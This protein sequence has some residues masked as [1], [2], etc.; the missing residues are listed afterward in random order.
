MNVPVIRKSS[1]PTIQDNP[2]FEKC[3]WL[4]T[5]VSPNRIYAYNE[6]TK[7]WEPISDIGNKNLNTKDPIE[8]YRVWIGTKD[9][10]ENLD[11]LEDDVIYSVKGVGD[12]IGNKPMFSMIP[13]VKFVNKDYQ[14]KRNLGCSWD[15]PFKNIQEAIDNALD[16][17]RIWV[18]SGTYVYNNPTNSTSS[19]LVNKKLE[20]IGGFT[21]NELSYSEKSLSNKT[22]LDGEKTRR[23]FS[24]GNKSNGSVVEGFSLVNG[25]AGNENGGAI[26]STGSI[27]I[28][29]CEFKNNS[30]SLGGAVYNVTTILGCIF[31]KNTATSNG[32]SIFLT[33]QGIINSCTITRGVGNNAISADSNVT[34][35]L[36]NT[37]IWNNISGGDSVQCGSNSMVLNCAS[38]SNLSK[39]SNTNI[40]LDYDGSIIFTDPDNGDFSIIKDSP[41]INKGLLNVY[42]LQSDILGGNRISHGSIDIGAYEFQD[43]SQVFTVNGKTGDVIIESK[44]IEGLDDSISKVN[45]RIDEILISKGQPNGI[46]TLGSDGKIPSDQLPD[47]SLYIREGYLVS[48]DTFNDKNGNPYP[49][50]VDVIYVDITEGQ[51][52]IYRWDN[53]K[54]ISLGTKV[55][56][57]TNEGQAYPGNMGADLEKLIKEQADKLSNVDEL[58]IALGIDNIDN[59]SDAAKPISEATERRINAIEDS[60]AIKKDDLIDGKIP[61]ALLPDSILGALSFQGTW[62]PDL[63]IPDLTLP[64]T[65]NRGDYYIAITNGIKFGFE[66]EPGDWI[67][68]TSKTPEAGVQGWKKVDNVDSVVSVNGKKGVVLIGIDDIPGLRELLNSSVDNAALLNHINNKINP[69]SVTKDQLGLSNVDN[70]SDLDKPISNAANEKF[71]QVELNI[72][73]VTDKVTKLTDSVDKPLGLVSLNDS[74]IVSRDKLPLFIIEG[75]LIDSVTFNDSNSNKVTP[76]YGVLYIDVTEGVNKIYRW[77][78]SVFVALAKDE[79]EVINTT[80]ESLGLSAWVGLTP[81]TLQ[82]TKDL[83]NHKRDFENPHKVTKAQIGL[84]NV[85][86]TSDVDKPVSNIQKEYIDNISKSIKEELVEKFNPSI[87]HLNDTNNPHKVTAE[88]LGL[89]DINIRLN[90]KADLDSTGRLSISQLPD[91]AKYCTRYIGLWDAAANSPRLENNTIE[92]NG[93]Y[94]IVRESGNWHGIKFYQDD[95]IIN[96]GGTWYKICGQR[97]CTELEERVSKLE[98]L[99]EDLINNGNNSQDYIKITNLTS[100]AGV[101]F[102]KGT[103]QSTTLTWSTNFVPDKITINGVEVD[104]NSTSYEL[105]NITT[106]NEYVIEVTK[107]SSTAKSSIVIEFLTGMF[108]GTGTPTTLDELNTNY[109]LMLVKPGESYNVSFSD[110]GTQVLLMT[111]EY[112]T[113]QGIQ[114]IDIMSASGFNE[115]WRK[116]TLNLEGTEFISYSSPN[117]IPG[118]VFKITIK[119]NG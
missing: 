62:S 4:N 79:I 99:V 110:Y 112:V 68:Y 108:I 118:Q 16:G 56:L 18:T 34:L 26:H 40:R 102:L 61:N 76:E 54:Y 11:V 73:S 93:H 103:T 91:I 94:Y 9:Q 116:G 115:Y 111:D 25:T 43:N 44:D 27:T 86:N 60:I 24:F 71:S 28:R 89:G 5:S 109:T 78:G 98:K 117:E 88:Q 75:K 83:D 22:I 70:T 36:Y 119:S 106:T 41:L 50:E 23:L 113:D 85:N 95:F 7:T 53:S 10:F 48:P 87:D 33:K 74:G 37:V 39:F 46:A 2:K 20:F 3:I 101:E 12:F 57:G 72:T 96:A 82:V 14:G 77:D 38:T 45:E 19:Y 21:G 32:N 52:L 65:W 58:R 97:C 104:P 66:F 42:N 13:K 63:N 29:Y 64:T 90:N 1:E 59:T 114:G 47:E 30:A 35:Q 107:G 6:E 80:A 55:E 49:N 84:S 15:F 81:E 100:S 17:D 69:H 105:T 67:I 8:N 92:Q 31:D 51:N